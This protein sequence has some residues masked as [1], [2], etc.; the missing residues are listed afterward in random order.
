MSY[1]EDGIKIYVND[2]SKLLITNVM[3]NSGLSSSQL[4]SQLPSFINSPKAKGTKLPIEEAFQMFESYDQERAKME[5]ESTQSIIFQIYP[6]KLFSKIFIDMMFT[7]HAVFSIFEIDDPN[8][9]KPNA[10]HT[11]AIIA[12]EH[13]TN[14]Q[15][16]ECSVFIFLSKFFLKAAKCANHDFSEFEQNVIQRIFKFMNHNE[17]NTVRRSAGEILAAMSALPKLCQ[18]IC[19]VFWNQ[20]G[21][22]KKEIEFRNFATWVDGVVNLNFSFHPVEVAELSL[23]FLRTFITMSKKIDRGVLRMKFLDA[24]LGIIKKLVIDSKDHIRDDFKALVVEIWGVVI[25]WST[26]GKHTVFCYLFLCNLISVCPFLYQENAYNFAQLLAKL[27]KKGDKD[28]LELLSLFFNSIPKEISD[29][30]VKDLFFEVFI[31]N[32]VGSNDK[33]RVIRFELEEQHNLIVDFFK[34]VGDRSLNVYLDF[35]NGILSVDKPAEEHKYVRLLTLKALSMMKCFKTYTTSINK[36]S[37]YFIPLL[38]ENGPEI[39]YILSVFPMIKPNDQN[40][41]KEM[42][43]IIY[44]KIN[45]EE[46]KA[47]I[48]RFIQYCVSPTKNFDLAVT[49]LKG[50]LNNPLILMEFGT[51][52]ASAMQ[53]S[54]N[55]P[56]LLTENSEEAKIWLDFRVSLDAALL[57][58]IINGNNDA[59]NCSIVFA[60]ESIHRLD[61]EAIGDNNVVTLSQIVKNRDPNADISLESTKI[62]QACEKYAIRLFNDKIPTQMP[63]EGGPKCLEFKLALAIEANDYSRAYITSVMKLVSDDPS[64]AICFT[65]FPYQQWLFLLK[66]KGQLQTSEHW[67]SFV[68]VLYRISQQPNFPKILSENYELA[69]I[70][71]PILHKWAKK[72]KNDSVLDERAFNFL[73]QYALGGSR[74]LMCLHEGH[75]DNFISYLLNKSKGATETTIVAML[76]CLSTLLSKSTLERT[77]SFLSFGKWLSTLAQENKHINLIQSRII[78]LLTSTVSRDPRMLREVFRASLNSEN[79]ANYVVAI[80][81]IL[82]MENFDDIYS[83]G[84]SV[85][86][87]TIVSHIDSDDEHSRQAVLKIIYQCH[88]KKFFKSESFSSDIVITSLSPSGY[89]LQSKN[90]INYLSLN[91]SD[92]D[93]K[94]CIMLIAEDFAYFEEQ[95]ERII[96]NMTPLV[97]RMAHDSGTLINL[98]N[99]TTK[100]RQD[101]SSIAT[102]MKKLWN[103]YFLV[104][105]EY[106]LARQVFQYALNFP[107]NSPEV[108]ASCHVLADVFIVKPKDVSDVLIP[109]LS[110]YERKSPKSFEEFRN[111]IQKS[112]VKFD[113][114]TKEVV[115]S[116]TMSEILL[117]LDNQEIFEKFILSNLTSLTFFAIIEYHTENLVLDGF[118]PLLDAIIDVSL[119]R[120]GSSNFTENITN[121]QKNNLMK[122]AASLVE[123]NTL[124]LSNPVKQML[125]YDHTAVLT[126]AILMK[127]ILPKFPEEIFEIVFANAVR[128]AKSD[129]SMEPMVMMMALSELLNTRTFFLL[130]IY[131]LYCLN[132]KRFEMLDPIIDVLSERLT[133]SDLQTDL[134]EKEVVAVLCTL[135]CILSCD[136]KKSFL[137]NTV[138][139]GIKLISKVV[140]RKISIKEQISMFIEKF[141][142]EEYICSLIL[143]FIVES[144]SFNDESVVVSCHFLLC[145][146]EILGDDGYCSLFGRLIDATRYYLSVQGQCDIKVFQNDMKTAKEYIEMMISQYPD[147]TNFIVYYSL[148]LVTAFNANDLY[149]E[150]VSAEFLCHSIEKGKPKLSENAVKDISFYLFNLPLNGN[151]D[152][153]RIATKALYNLISLY[154]DTK[155]DLDISSKTPKFS[156]KKRKVIG[157]WKLTEFNT[158]DKKLLPILDMFDTEFPEGII[159]GMNKF[160]IN[161]KLPDL[162][163]NEKESYEPDFTVKSENQNEEEI[164]QEEETFHLKSQKG[165]DS[166]NFV[167]E[168]PPIDSSNV[169]ENDEEE[170]SEISDYSDMESIKKTAMSFMPQQS[171]VNSQIPTVIVP[172]IVPPSQEE[173]DDESSSSLVLSSDSEDVIFT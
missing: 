81:N 63:D 158:I 103:D 102:A 12:E 49:F 26:K 116:N 106:Y 90:F 68:N 101:S 66:T 149:M 74:A 136:L 39:P 24:L 167:F 77:D 79:P 128:S 130:L 42:V 4:Q 38:N 28:I 85:I 154:P 109:V 94:G 112:D 6:N 97:K 20:F 122:S 29:E 1:F 118:Y 80:S 111:Y 107:Q 139:T 36:L 108:V 143:P 146:S 11:D 43:H 51:S 166:Q 164:P 50:T 150:F 76:D 41:L 75:L 119:L 54:N 151:K 35:M 132:E 155:L 125:C 18:I 93:L 129:R 98:L 34:S 25:K 72:K 82:S 23:Q 123:Q 7:T 159:E 127:Q 121:L 31:P 48:S 163:E 138:K 71:T 46:G 15:T 5:I 14:L 134:F 78:S 131:A 9:K 133:N 8:E 53:V 104:S 2:W 32:I 69:Q 165:N 13:L 153:T 59:I 110:K 62:V 140:E 169:Y 173:D 60:D 120:L 52:F 10:L 141:G 148:N 84:R 126:I 64:F 44:T 135:I 45:T 56:N 171:S 157:G 161:T 73:N 83:G 67:P 61:K 145:L 89:V 17:P 88:S 33:K 70:L 152:L 170:S 117:Q 137:V 40:Q 21:T 37:E 144:D 19:E 100:V 92:I 124:I 113:I 57:K 87:A 16:F 55:L 105:N 91:A 22:C 47:A 168:P 65:N 172:P 86:L 95:Q 58:L 160:L 156:M 142:G 115:A 27:V 162:T 3:M 147:K 96:P 30:S 114:T 99:M